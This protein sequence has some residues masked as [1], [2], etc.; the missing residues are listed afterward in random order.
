M[1]EEQSIRDFHSTLGDVLTS[2]RLVSEAAVRAKSFSLSCK[3]EL[4]LQQRGQNSTKNFCRFRT[5]LLEQICRDKKQ[6]VLYAI[7][8]FRNKVLQLSEYFNNNRQEA[9]RNYAALPQFN[10]RAREVAKRLRLDLTLVKDEWRKHLRPA[11]VDMVEKC[12]N[13]WGDVNRIWVSLGP[14]KIK[15]RGNIRS[16]A[17]D[18]A[19]DIYKL[20][21]AESQKRMR[22]AVEN[23]LALM[24]NK[25]E[26]TV[27][28]LDQPLLNHQVGTV[29]CVL[30]NIHVIHHSS[31]Y[32]P[33]HC[34]DVH[35]IHHNPNKT[36]NMN[37]ARLE[38][39][40]KRSSTIFWTIFTRPKAVPLPPHGVLSRASWSVVL[41]VCRVSGESWLGYSRPL[42]LVW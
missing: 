23:L 7:N 37:L 27:Q 15:A 6:H 4:Q 28:D 24:V 31:K 5:E 12:W 9:E 35:A 3:A 18:I 30:L 2:N 13:K 19:E 33:P 42:R 17:P 41:L 36:L 40:S 38:L 1:K 25:F 14:E 29:S 26:H 11:L 20:F 21:A 34:R 16:L 22:P 8:E 32:D 10:K 39:C